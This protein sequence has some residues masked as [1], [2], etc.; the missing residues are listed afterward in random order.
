MFSIDIKLVIMK[1][2][3]TLLFILSLVALN[4][5]AQEFRG[6]DQSPLDRA[7]LPDDYAHDRK[8]APERNL[9]ETAI[10]RID[11][12]RPQKK[13]REIF[14]VIVK[15]NEVWRLGANEATEIK[16]YKD[17]NIGGKFLKRGTYSMF[18]IPTK[19]NWTIIFNSDLDEWGHYSYNKDH[20]VLKVETPVLENREPVE[21]FSIQF[22]D[23]E[24]GKAVMHIAWD[25]TRVELVISY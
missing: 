23:L 9:G 22:N 5:F 25:M 19:D 11:Y 20:D 7:Y 24:E 17:I 1:K 3:K 21:E 8:F 12:S 4:C 15:Y 13:G 10:I 6:L 2:S 14:G 18:A 16:V